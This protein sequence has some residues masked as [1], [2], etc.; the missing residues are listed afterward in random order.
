MTDPI[1]ADTERL[2]AAYQ[3]LPRVEPPAA[4]DRAILAHARASLR[5]ARPR[6]LRPVAAAAVVVLAFGVGWQLREV[7]FGEGPM[8]PT[9]ADSTDAVEVLREATQAE[10]EAKDE[11]LL[12]SAASGAGAAPQA[13]AKPA[14]GAAPQSPAPAARADG[15]LAKANEP[16]REERRE[17]PSAGEDRRR[18]L[19]G[20][21]VPPM[22]QEQAQLP[23]QPAQMAPPPAPP[24]PPP[25]AA[26]PVVA[27]KSEALD[28]S[29][30]EVSGTPAAG[31]RKRARDAATAEKNIAVEST[32]PTVAPAEAAAEAPDYAP[33]EA[34][35]EA[36]EFAP[37][38]ALA[39][40]PATST[41]ADSLSLGAAV[42]SHR[43]AQVWLRDIRRLREQGELTRAREELVR[44]RAAWPDVEI[45]PELRELLP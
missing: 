36:A 28:R 34:P 21:D 13:S 7:P 32:M 30:V 12:D 38:P 42:A 2:V 25:P 11:P 37:D 17:R 14:P 35:A 40:P 19:E 6:W 23:A 4:L 9:P 20:P 15:N 24:A 5:P 41:E 29:A 3:A 16:L 27:G 33:A 44:F 43:D 10:P 22:Q 1:D 18:E 45:P 8:S 31:A 26:A 39:E